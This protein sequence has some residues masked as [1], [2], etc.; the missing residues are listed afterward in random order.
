M[1]PIPY[2]S[3]RSGAAAAGYVCPHCET[4]LDM[5]AQTMVCSDCGYVPKHGAD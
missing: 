4:P 1:T 5:N 3:S 2:D